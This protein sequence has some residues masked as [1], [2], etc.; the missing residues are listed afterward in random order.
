MVRCGQCHGRYNGGRQTNRF[1]QTTMPRPNITTASSTAADNN[2]PITCGVVFLSKCGWKILML[3]LY[4]ALPGSGSPSFHAWPILGRVAFTLVACFWKVDTRR[5]RPFAA[6][7][8]VLLSIVIF[9]MMSATSTYG[10]VGGT[11]LGFSTGVYSCYLA[12]T[13]RNT[14][15]ELCSIG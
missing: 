1:A 3:V 6:L 5:E 11:V 12:L 8:S 14:C 13:L 2:G 9:H 7:F 10:G 15:G 4:T